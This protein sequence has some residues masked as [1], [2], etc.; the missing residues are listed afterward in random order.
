MGRYFSKEEKKNQ[1]QKSKCFALIFCLN[2]LSETWLIKSFPI[3]GWIPSSSFTVSSFTTK[4]HYIFLQFFIVDPIPQTYKNW[5]KKLIWTQNSII[6][7]SCS[8]Q[9]HVHIQQ[10]NSVLFH[11]VRHTNLN[12]YLTHFWSIFF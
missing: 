12:S 11:Q 7:K 4:S 3:W 10:A 9:N 8:T 5:S 6:T 2:I 1:N